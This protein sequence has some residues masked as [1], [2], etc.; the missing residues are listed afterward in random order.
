MAAKPDP[1]LA[2]LAG[3]QDPLV[4]TALLRALPVTLPD[5][6]ERSIGRLA[7]DPDPLVRVLWARHQTQIALHG[8]ATVAGTLRPHKALKSAPSL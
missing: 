1:R 2:T 4:K 7:T 6:L 3:A 8:T 5:D